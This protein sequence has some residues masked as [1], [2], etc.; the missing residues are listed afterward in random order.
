MT[1][2]DPGS[3]ETLAEAPSFLATDGSGRVPIVVITAGAAIYGVRVDELRG[4]QEIVLKPLPAQ[5]GQLPGVAG[6]TIMG[7]GSVALI[8]DPA[9]L[10]DFVVSPIGGTERA[11]M[12]R[13]A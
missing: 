12:E 8:L 3:R 10:Y 7:D 6:A 5:L 9:S 1:E 4:K 11:S 2:R 13:R